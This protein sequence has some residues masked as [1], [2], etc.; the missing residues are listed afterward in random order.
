MVETDLV[1]EEARTRAFQPAPL[2]GE[3]EVLARAAARQQG[4]FAAL[5]EELLPTELCHVAVMGDVGPTVREHARREG[6][7]LRMK[8][9]LP[10][11]PIKAK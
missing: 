2:P 11:S 1:V 10:P 6:I 4:D 5:A 9:G 7:D 8:S 3:A